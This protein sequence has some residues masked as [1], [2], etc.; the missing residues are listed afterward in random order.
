MGSKATKT[1]GLTILAAVLI[2]GGFLLYITIT[3]YKPEEIT[4]L[5]VKQNSEQVLK[6][7]EPFSITTFN[8]G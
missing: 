7:R 1:I 4:P 2:F 3:D 8:I 6:H 5:Q